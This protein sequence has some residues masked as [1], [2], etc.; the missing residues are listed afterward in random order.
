MSRIVVDLEAAR[1]AC[2]GFS[3]FAI[4]LGGALPAACQSDLKLSYLVA[5]RTESYFPATGVDFIPARTWRQEQFVRHLRPLLSGFYRDVRCDAWHTSNQ[6]GRYFPVNPAVPVI[7]TIHDLNFL[8]EFDG[9]RIDEELQ[10]LQR[11]VDRATVITAISEFVRTEILNTLNVRGKEVQVIYN[12]AS[13]ATQTA[14]RP[15]FLPEAPILFSI[16]EV[17]KRKNFHV[18][19][20][21]IER[22]PGYVLVIAG[23]KS[24]EYAR[25]I[26]TQVRAKGL[27]DRV[28]LPGQISAG[29]RLWLYQNCEALLFPSRTEGFG[30][31]VIEAMSAGRPVFMSHA[32]SLPEVGGPLGFYWHSFDIEHM[33]E[34]FHQG[35]RTFRS[36][37]DYGDRLK[38]H[39][40]QFTWQRTAE[41]YAA[42]YRSV[43]AGSSSRR[44]A[45]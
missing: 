8:R 10:K 23:N 39:A 2:C 32:T 30:L 3:Q 22:L 13:I 1:L 27:M 35:M 33:C 21:L 37:P 26:E 40:A 41:Q 19:L 34:V 14:T 24:S 11:K 7:L 31:P 36:T 16:G 20:D 38:R 12:G 44:K 5:P 45:A 4:S 43:A 18:L 28:F 9:P 6:F 15:A 25:E 29:E 42:L 17:Q